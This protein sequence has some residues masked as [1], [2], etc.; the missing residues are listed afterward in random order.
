MFASVCLAQDPEP[1]DIK[2]NDICLMTEKKQP[3]SHLFYFSALIYFDSNK[4]TLWINDE[5][6]QPNQ[7]CQLP[8]KINVQ[9]NCV[10]LTVDNKDYTL[11]PDQSFNLDDKKI[12][13]G[14]ARKG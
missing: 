14:D 12:I 8:F 4:W 9:Q 6:I 13:N 2:E 3:E 5:K 11:M 7:Q 10:I 1:T